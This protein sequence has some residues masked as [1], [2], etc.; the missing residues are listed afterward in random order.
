MIYTD[1]VARLH[2]HS[3]YMFIMLISSVYRA[4]RFQINEAGLVSVDLEKWA[5]PSCCV[6]VI[7]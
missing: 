1:S 5:K 7:T 6:D 2:I 3:L 4:V